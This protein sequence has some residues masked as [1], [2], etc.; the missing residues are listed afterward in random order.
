MRRLHWTKQIVEILER[1]CSTGWCKT[2]WN[3]SGNLEIKLKAS[4]NCDWWN[5]HCF[6]E[7]YGNRSDYNYAVGKPPKFLTWYKLKWTLIR[8]LGVENRRGT[9]YNFPSSEILGINYESNSDSLRS[10]FCTLADVEI[11]FFPKFVM[12]NIENKQ[13]NT[14]IHHLW[15]QTLTG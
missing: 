1:N 4:S 14:F 2:D 9:P 7:I 5:C 15:H 11:D 3:G 10:L 6:G 12:L 13:N 8:Y